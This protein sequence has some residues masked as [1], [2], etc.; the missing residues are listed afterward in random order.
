MQTISHRGIDLVC[1][2]H[3]NGT[4]VCYIKGTQINVSFSGENQFL[5]FSFADAIHFA[6][7][8]IDKILLLG[9]V[10]KHT[11]MSTE[12]YEKYSKNKSHRPDSEL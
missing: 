9:N 6:K 4:Y 2:N 3:D 5:N 8:N 1:T 11:H 10:D 12:L 7:R